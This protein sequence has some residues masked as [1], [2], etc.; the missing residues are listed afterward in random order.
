MDVHLVAV[1]GKN[2]GVA[3]PLSPGALILGRDET[4]DVVLSDPIA[5]RRHCRIHVSDGEVCLEDLGSRNPALING[6]PAKEACLKPGDEIAIGRQRFML[7]QFRPR[8]E[9]GPGGSGLTDTL[10]WEE[11]EAICVDVGSAEAA[12]QGRPRTVQD[13]FMLYEV[14]RDFGSCTVLSDL[15]SAVQRVLVCRFEPQRLWIAVGR[16]EAEFVFFERNRLTQE[17]E[18]D[19]PLPEIRA[20]LEG[21]RGLLAPSTRKKAGKKERLL[22]LTAPVPLGKVNLGV[23]ALQTVLPQGAFDEDDLLLLVL[24]GQS[25]APVMYAVQNLERLRT[26]NERLR[27]RAGESSDLVGSSRAIR[28]IRAQIARAAQS[29]LPVL[30]TGE[31]GTGKELAARTLHR[32]SFRATGPFV[33]VN[34]AAIPRELFESQIFGHEKGAFTG[35]TEAAAGLLSEAN[36]GILFLDEI[37]DLSADNQARILRAIETGTFR[38]VGANK[39][40]HADIRV[41]AAT[42]K[43]LERAIQIGAF[44]EDLFHRL[45]G[46]EIQIPPLRDRPSDIPVLVQHFFQMAQHAAKHPLRGVDPEAVAYL[47]AQAWPGNVRELRNRVL[48]AVSTAN[49]DTIQVKDVMSHVPVAGPPDAGEEFLS[50]AALEQ[51]HIAQ[52]FRKC[53]GNITE[54]ARILEIGRSTLYR[55]LAE[56]GIG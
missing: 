43:D 25:L 50:L 15:L 38:R 48:R 33:V 31:T 3:W 45:N 36:G 6:V 47:R 12:I 28:R 27:N 29:E 49:Q 51:R 39:E 30:I 22:T 14:S 21:R 53:G 24:L 34:C 4:N 5:S 32:R 35:A 46:F 20:A 54:T 55:K 52:A 7:S 10:P 11:G 9:T 23:L 26:D 8:E 56:Y 40:T 41:V 19:P 17:P 16:S 44:R 13:L 37:G 1:S 18:A 42:N 2:K